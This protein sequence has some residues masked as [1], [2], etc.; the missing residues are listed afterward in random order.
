MKSI[1]MNLQVKIV[2]GVAVLLMVGLATII[3]LNVY[4]QQKS[5]S[6]QREASTSILTDAI[7]NSILYPM[8]IGDGETI[9]RQMAEFEKN[10]N[11]VKVYV[12]GFDTRITYTSEHDR[13]NSLLTD[14]IKSPDLA[15]GIDNMLTTGE[16]PQ[17]GFHDQ[18]DGIHFLSLLRPLQNEKRCHHCHG[19]NRSVLGGLLVERNSNSVIEAYSDIC[20]KNILIGLCCSLGVVLLLILIVSR[21]VSRPIQGVISGLNEATESAWEASGAV[22]AIS[23]QMS[24][25]AAGQAAAIEQTSAFL[26]E[27]STMTGHNSGNAAEADKLMHHVGEITSKA[28]GSMNRLMEFM[29]EISSASDKTQKIIRTIDE[30][31]FQTNLL[32]LNAAVEAARAGEAG[33]GFA[34]VADE[35]RNLAMRAAEAAK[36]TAALIEGN[37]TMIQT[38][39][40]LVKSMSGEFQEVASS[41]S[42]AG[43]LVREISS[44]SQEQ[45]LGVQQIAQAVEGIDKVAQENAAN[46]KN[47]ASASTQLKE[48]AE[49]MLGF[50]NRLMNLL[51][52]S[53]DEAG[54]ETAGGE[55]LRERE[56][57]DSLDAPDAAGAQKHKAA[58]ADQPGVFPVPAMPGDSKAA[59][60]H[61][62]ATNGGGSYQTH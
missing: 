2:V 55:M 46:A 26:E 44:A 1:K 58:G 7:Y 49:Q 16:R 17:S 52:G 5:M 62:R 60:K 30:I 40:D 43:D 31:A 32:A 45:A 19:S 59:G 53:S 25:G 9:M 34:V 12:F 14:T 29:H 48:Q 18:R 47:A 39:N 3:G 13:T 54:T 33:A 15:K 24:E 56:A 6:E 38:G 50:V 57:K 21:V 28:E 22:A 35:V 4:Y 61:V 36:N 42:K 41:V 10:S 27:M 51:E 11:N 20:N 23:G 37:V 8:A